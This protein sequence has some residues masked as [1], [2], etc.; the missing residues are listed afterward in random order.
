[1]SEKAKI[2]IVEDEAIIA[3]TL[4]AALT[5]LGYSVG[6]HFTTGEDLIE[7]LNMLPDNYVPDLILMDI[8][9]AGKLDGI[10][11][12]NIVKSK[13]DIPVIYLTAFSNETIIKKAKVSEPYAYILK[14]FNERELH[15]SIEIALY[16]YQSEL[17]IK[18]SEY[19]KKRIIARLISINT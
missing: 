17:K 14:P 8:T 11:T 18:K 1:M 19:Y 13:H 3:L 7:Y 10:E 15:I 4:T 9:L 5:R 12:V 6:A 2:V 16:K